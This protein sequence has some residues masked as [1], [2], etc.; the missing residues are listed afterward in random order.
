MVSWDQS[1]RV[2]D[3]RDRRTIVDLEPPCSPRRDYSGGRGVPNFRVSSPD[4]GRVHRIAQARG[5]VKIHRGTLDQRNWRPRS[6]AYA[7]GAVYDGY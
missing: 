5:C 3:R 4:T 6:V 1:A 2:W 7:L